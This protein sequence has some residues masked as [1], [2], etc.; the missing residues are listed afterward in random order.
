[1]ISVKIQADH[2]WVPGVPSEEGLYWLYAATPD[3]EYLSCRVVVV[4]NVV[5]TLSGATKMFT[6]QERYAHKLIS[7]LVSPLDAPKDLGRV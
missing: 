6:A 2:D 4:T 3:W 7:R 5:R 1:M